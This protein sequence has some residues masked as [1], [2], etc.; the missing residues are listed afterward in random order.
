MPPK[1]ANKNPAKSANTKSKPSGAESQPTKTDDYLTNLFKD[2]IKQAEKEINN[3]EKQ[4]EKKDFQLNGFA[5]EIER[6]KKELTKQQGTTTGNS[7][8][9]ENYEEQLENERKKCKDEIEKSKENHEKEIKRTKDEIEILKKN[10]ENQIKRLT[11]DTEKSRNQSTE[12]SEVER[13][14]EQLEKERKK[15]K[16]EIERLKK[17]HENEIKRTKDEIEKLRKEHENGIKRLNIDNEKS[18][19]QSR[20]SSEIEKLNEQLES[21][22]RKTTVEFDK[23]KKGHEEEIKRLTAESEKLRKESKDAHQ[24]IEEEKRK[25]ENLQKENKEL[26]EDFEKRKEQ[27]KNNKQIKNLPSGDIASLRQENETLKNRLS[28]LAGA[29]LTEGNPNIADLSDKNR[30]TN[31]AEH[32]SELYDNEWTDALEELTDSESKSEEEG[33][34]ILFDIVKDAYAFSSKQATFFYDSVSKGMEGFGLENPN[35]WPHGLSKQVKD[36][37]KSISVL[38]AG[39]LGQAFLKNQKQKYG[40]ATAKYAEACAALCLYMCVQ[41]PAVYIDSDVPKGKFDKDKYRAYTKSG[42]EYAFLV[43]PPLFLHKEGPMLGKGIAQGSK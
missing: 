18:L 8:K 21:E 20:E 4:L 9:A 1:T 39:T 29:K 31:L 41:D 7:T 37:R 12:N 16:D 17:D 25:T 11:T 2:Q 42:E 28:Q 23:L 38:V 36:H 32:F 6:L 10:Y 5:A 40:K 14:K 22:R 19:N 43:W 15:S 34:K 26:L 3:L 35:K 33:I 27:S 13:L 24:E 30:P